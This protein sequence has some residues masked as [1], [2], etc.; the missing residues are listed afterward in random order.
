LQPT[1]EAVLLGSASQPLQYL[2]R[3]MY[4]ARRRPFSESIVFTPID[5]ATL[6]GDWQSIT[7][8]P[9][10]ATSVVSGDSPSA[11]SLTDAGQIYRLTTKLLE[12]GGFL[13]VAERLILS[14]E[15]K[16]PLLARSL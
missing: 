7:G 9:I 16:D 3:M 2:E 8:S 10:L 12:T 4:V 14:D 11:V 13:S 5:R 15:L 6:A 1:Q